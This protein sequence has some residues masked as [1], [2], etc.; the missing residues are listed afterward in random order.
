MV[1]ISESEVAII[2]AE[3]CNV[4]DSTNSDVELSK[5]HPLLCTIVHDSWYP[6]YHSDERQSLDSSAQFTISQ[7][8]DGPTRPIALSIRVEK[9][10]KGVDFALDPWDSQPKFSNALKQQ[11]RRPL[12][13]GIPWSIRD[14]YPLKSVDDYLVFHCPEHEVLVIIDFWPTW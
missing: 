5:P 10:G 1:P 3:Q 7:F 8:P 2:F 11:M 13:A 6:D 9:I 4:N 12:Q 14:D